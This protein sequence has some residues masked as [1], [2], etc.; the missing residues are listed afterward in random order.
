MAEW[1]NTD[2]LR[3]RFG[4]EEAEVTRG[5]ELPSAG[6]SREVTFNLTLTT[7]GSGSALVPDTMGVFI[8]SGARIF[9][10]EVLNETAA[11]SGGSATLNLGLNRLDTTTAI[12]VDGLL[13]TAP[14]ADFNLAGE[15]KVY[16]IGVTGVGA[17]VGTTLANPGVLVADYDTAAF[18]AGELRITVRFYIPRPAASN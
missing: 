9:E 1:I 12:D 7:L 15:T 6:T 17:L 14:L 3:V 18:T 11:T 16:T 5:G 8:P 2:G 10:I 13:V 4:T